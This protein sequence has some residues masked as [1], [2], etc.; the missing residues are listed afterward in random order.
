VTKNKFNIKNKI[1]VITG[2]AGLFGKTH[3]EAVLENG[4]N[5]IILDS[6]QKKLSKLKKII[7]LKFIDRKFECLKCDIT[8]EKEV[9]RALNY[10]KKK[11]KKIDVLINNAAIDYPPQK[12]KKNIK[13][14]RLET[15]NLKTFENDL[16]VSLS[17]SVIC[18][19]YFGS[20]MAKKKGGII[21]NI[22]SDLSIISP[23]QRL[24][25]L[26]NSNNYDPVKPISYSL[27]KHGIIG[28][29]KYLAT[30]WANKNVRCNALAPGGISTNQPKLFKKKLSKLIPL[31]RMARQNEYKETV[32]Y[33]IS[34]ASSYMNGFTMIVDGG[35]TIW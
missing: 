21:L 1:V 20:E 30:Y 16:K 23:D 35:R 11:Y 22:A 4:G 28:L 33:M 17:G 14:I 9:K 31:G 26:K 32:L 25:K 10:I 6:D 13:S 12:S 7:K 27:T 5:S 15:L 8:K 2:G 18:A 19:K 24:Y 3:I 34:D 29:T